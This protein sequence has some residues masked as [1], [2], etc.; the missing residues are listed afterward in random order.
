[1]PGVV[2]SQPPQA[3]QRKKSKKSRSSKAK[4]RPPPPQGVPESASPGDE[5]PAPP[6]PP[7]LRPPPPG[8]GLSA[9]LEEESSRS[10]CL[11][12][13]LP[14]LLAGM[15]M[16]LAGMVLHTVQVRGAGP[17]RTDQDPVL[18]SRQRHRADTW[19]PRGGFSTPGPTMG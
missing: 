2:D 9:R 4:G 16:V 8:K 11:Q 3:R 13:V 10:M 7:G 17:H 15:G 14:F 6:P 1:M 19:S 12:V 18:I 5:A